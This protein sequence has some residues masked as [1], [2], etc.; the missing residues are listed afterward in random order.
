M[1]QGDTKE[2]IGFIIGEDY[3]LDDSILSFNK[4]EIDIYSCIGILWK[5]EQKLIQQV[6]D[7]IEENIKLKSMI[8]NYQIQNKGIM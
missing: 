1:A 5:G 4:T 2:R 3:K 7:L 8:E 6:R